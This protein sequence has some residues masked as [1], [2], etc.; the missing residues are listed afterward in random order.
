MNKVTIEWF[1]LVC[2]LLSNRYCRDL[3]HRT[4]LDGFHPFPIITV[5]WLPRISLI[6]R[7]TSRTCIVRLAPKAFTLWW[8]VILTRISLMAGTYTI[9][10]T[11][12]ASIHW[13]QSSRLSD[14]TSYFAYITS[15]PSRTCIVVPASKAFRLWWT[16][17]RLSDFD[18]YFTY[19]RDLHHRTHIDGFHPLMT[20]V[21]VEWF[22]LVFRLYYVK[23]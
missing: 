1:W 18:S 14:F 22:Y 7:H 21:T 9:G 12:M 23:S 13:W 4:H 3:Y 15:N 17:S 16:K 19:G 2:H 10:L 8:R 5:E 20:V 11:S 6:L